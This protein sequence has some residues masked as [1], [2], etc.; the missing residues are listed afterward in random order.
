MLPKAR[1]T[2]RLEPIQRS[3]I[4]SYFTLRPSAV[5]DLFYDGLTD[6]DE[7]IIRVQDLLNSEENRHFM[8][9]LYSRGPYNRHVFQRFANKSCGIDADVADEIF[10]CVTNAFNMEEESPTQND[11]PDMNMSRSE[12]AG[13][14]VRLA[15]LWVLMNEGMADSSKLASQTTSFLLN[16][17][18]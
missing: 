4:D 7:E 14:I 6:P 1:S 3:A 15:N 17:R 11:L 2:G 8:N 9:A 10:S 18:D 13:G 12:F 5:D 16:V